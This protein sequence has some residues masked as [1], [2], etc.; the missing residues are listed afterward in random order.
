MIR[1]SYLLAPK[2]MGEEHIVFGEDPG[3][4]IYMEITLG[5]DGLYRLSFGDID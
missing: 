3:K 2:G 5:R 4:K 1:H